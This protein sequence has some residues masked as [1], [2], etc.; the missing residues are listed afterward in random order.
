[1]KKQV[2]YVMMVVLVLILVGCTAC[3][4]DPSSGSI[5]LTAER[6][7]LCAPDG[8]VAQESTYDYLDDE[9]ELCT[10][11]EL[12]IIES[13]SVSGNLMCHVKSGGNISDT[14]EVGGTEQEPTVTFYGNL[15]TYVIRITASN[16]EAP[17]DLTLTAIDDS[18]QIDKMYFSLI[19]GE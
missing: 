7:L 9:G 18:S 11:D 16:A 4:N 8:W 12:L 2:F 10:V 17:P 19:G 5:D 6:S 14:G 3:E 15:G 13:D 1:M